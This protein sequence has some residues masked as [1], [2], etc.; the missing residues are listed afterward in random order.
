[1]KEGAKQAFLAELV[2]RY[3]PIRK[4]GTGNSLFECSGNTLF[5]IRYSKL[6]GQTGTRRLMMSESERDA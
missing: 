1:M 3:G 4:L 5:Y 6:H 2:N